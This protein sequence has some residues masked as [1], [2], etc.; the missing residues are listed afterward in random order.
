MNYKVIFLDVDGTLFDHFNGKVPE[1]AIEAVKLAKEKGIK[2]VLSTGRSMALIKELGVDKLVDADAYITCNG[3]ITY[4]KR[5]QIIDA[6]PFKRKQIMELIYQ[7]HSK[8]LRL[9]IVPKGVNYLNLELTNDAK[10]AF[11]DLRIGYPLVKKIIDEEI[12]QLVLFANTQQAQEVSP[13]LKDLTFKQFHPFAYDIFAPG[14]N[15]G[16]AIKHY[17][18]SNQISKTQAVA[19]GDGHN[20]YEMMASVKYSVAMGNAEAELKKIAKFVTTPVNED[21]L[22]N[23]FK[24]LKIID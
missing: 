22:Y 17:L 12:Y 9:L 5:E 18:K 4:N 7:L 15:K 19:I 16:A 23:A 21:G 1:S 8:Q 10:G 6:F 3:A 24:D 2:I 20:D 14:V 13:L 11:D